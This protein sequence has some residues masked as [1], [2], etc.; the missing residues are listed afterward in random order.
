MAIVNE[1]RAVLTAED[2]ASAVLAMV[3]RNFDRL[4]R[5]A[6]RLDANGTV[7]RRNQV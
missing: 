7:S 2:R 3:A 1:A 4:D 6:S 5:A